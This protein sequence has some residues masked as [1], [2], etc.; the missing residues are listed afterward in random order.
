MRAEDVR[1]PAEGSIFVR[2]S[3]MSNWANC[4]LSV[5]ATS[6]PDY[7]H[8]STMQSSRGTG[9][10]LAIEAHLKGEPFALEQHFRQAWVTEMA[11]REEPIVGVASDAKIREV[12]A[13]IWKGYIE[14]VNQ[15]WYPVGQYLPIVATEQTLQMFLDTAPSGREIWLRG[16]PD[17][18]VGL[19]GDY[20]R[21][22]V[23][24]WKTSTS[25][26]S[27]NKTN[28]MTQ[29]VGYAIL[30]EEHG[31]ANVDQG[32]YVVYDFKNGGWKWDEYQLPITGTKKRLVF[33]EFVNM[34]VVIDGQA[35]SATPQK[36][37]AAWGQ[38]GRGW[39]CS[40]VWCGYWTPCQGKYLLEDG[41]AD[42]KRDNTITW[43]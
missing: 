43:R 30:L 12:S 17:T 36:R 28:D 14:W 5:Q 2:P 38:D 40:E 1:V 27:K 4:Q 32:M 16:T 31:F 29:H 15:F 35:A 9:M 26:W 8:A 33:S 21:H 24:D 41:K 42:E 6:Y 10:H 25:G 19:E 3:A 23:I 11:R 39:W 13:D 22:K 20:P 18:V 7:D 34:G 37:G